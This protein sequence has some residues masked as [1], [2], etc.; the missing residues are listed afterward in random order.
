MTSGAGNMKE[1]KERPKTESSGH[2]ELQCHKSAGTK[3][4]TKRRY[5]MRKKYSIFGPERV[6]N[7]KY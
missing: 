3:Q 4:N 5:E 1:Q 7:S 6:F 2:G